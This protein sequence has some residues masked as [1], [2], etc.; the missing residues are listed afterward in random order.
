MKDAQLIP[1]TSSSPASENGSDYIPAAG[2]VVEF[3]YDGKILEAIIF[4][5]NKR[6]FVDGLASIDN[7]NNRHYYYRRIKDFMRLNP[8]KVRTINIPASVY[9]ASSARK[10][11]ETYFDKAY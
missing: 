5:D 6:S 2:D 1:S 8:R 7:N 3:E 4:Y 11:A 10:F 9:D